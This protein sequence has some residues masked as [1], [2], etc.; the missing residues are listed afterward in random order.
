M[1]PHAARLPDA[2]KD[3][4]PQSE[5]GATIARVRE[6][7][8]RFV[9][10]IVVSLTLAS[11]AQAWDTK[12]F[13]AK[14]LEKEWGLPVYSKSVVGNEVTVNDEQNRKSAEWA[15]RKVDVK[16]IVEFYSQKLKIDPEHKTSDTGDDRY[17][18]K[19]PFDKDKRLLRRV[20]VKYD[21]DDRLVHVRFADDTIPEGEEIPE[22]E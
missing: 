9:S 7:H 22:D 16:T 14:T 1:R 5:D 11:M 13:N 8:M 19:F 21:N 10:C 18:Y 17:I 12:K 2:H 6:I 3:G 15:I 4:R 20:Y